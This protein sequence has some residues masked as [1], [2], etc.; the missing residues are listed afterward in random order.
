MSRI[1]TVTPAPPI[2]PPLGTTWQA[3]EAGTGPL[4]GG[5]EP[6][7]EIIRVR[8]TCRQ[9]TQE[10][11][12]WMFMP[13]YKKLERNRKITEPFHVGLFRFCGDCQAGD[14][15]RGE[16]AKLTTIIEQTRRRWEN[17]KTL[18][19]KLPAGRDLARNL[20]RYVDLVRFGSDRFTAASDQLKALNNWIAKNKPAEV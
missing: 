1:T 18:K 9:C 10:F 19:D 4:A 7:T 17:A 20:E 6:Y 16:V 3:E 14:E 8:K 15:R 12:G 5:L 13:A 11:D 2:N